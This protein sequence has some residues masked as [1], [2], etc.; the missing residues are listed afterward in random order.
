MLF[1][2][3]P[4]VA[5]RFSWKIDQLTTEITDNGALYVLIM[6]EDWDPSIVAASVV[7]SE[8][9]AVAISD[10][11]TDEPFSVLLTYE[12]SFKQ[13]WGRIAIPREIHGIAP[14]I[15]NGIFLGF[16]ALSNEGNVYIVEKDGEFTETKIPGAGLHSDDADG[17]GPVY[18]LIAA[19]ETYYAAGAGGQ[20][21]RNSGEEWISQSVGVEPMEGYGAPVWT[22]LLTPKAG[23]ILA[24]GTR[25]ADENDEAFSDADAW[26]KLTAEEM[27]AKWDEMD[28]EGPSEIGVVARFDGT[29]WSELKIDALGEREI[30]DAAVDAKGTLWVCGSDDLLLRS[31]DGVTFH[32]GHFPENEYHF[33]TMCAFN[34]DLVLGH[35][36]GLILIKDGKMSDLKP[37]VSASR[38]AVSLAPLLMTTLEDRICYVD[39]VHGINYWD[40]GQWDRFTIPTTLMERDFDG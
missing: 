36:E 28:A 6:A 24:V 26:E 16:M 13:P 30:C 40:G 5:A 11:S 34:E 3:R 17:R 2:Q 7:A 37:R 12:G 15:D 29:A 19:N 1:K 25:E 33:S 35:D 32:E 21:Y 20:V 4:T 18:D 39:R 9:F 14:R 22:A 10:L 8:R 31:E 27:V 38:A 23:V